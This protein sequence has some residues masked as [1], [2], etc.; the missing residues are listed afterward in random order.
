QLTPAKFFSSFTPRY[1]ENIVFIL[2]RCLIKVIEAYSNNPLG[3]FDIKIL[4]GN[5]QDL[6]RLRV[7]KYRVIFEDDGDQMSIYEIKHRQE[8]Y[9]G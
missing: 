7:G 4:K 5:Y 3:N 9:N 6:K 8:V 2:E 1:S